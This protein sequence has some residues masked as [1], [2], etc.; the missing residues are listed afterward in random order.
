MIGAMF[1]VITSPVEQTHQLMGVS[2]SSN[3]SREGKYRMQNH[4]H[5][6]LNVRSVVSCLA[7]GKA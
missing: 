7:T 3:F 6:Y 4:S 2:A 5:R 1:A